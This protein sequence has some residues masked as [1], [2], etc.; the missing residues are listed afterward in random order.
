[1]HSWCRVLH[2][3][4]Y[5]QLDANQTL[6]SNSAG[7]AGFQFSFLFVVILFAP[8]FVELSETVAVD[9]LLQVAVGVV[10][11][12]AVVVEDK[13]LAILSCVGMPD[14][15]AVNIRIARMR[16]LRPYITHYVG[17]VLVLVRDRRAEVALRHTERVEA[18]VQLSAVHRAV[19]ARRAAG[20]HV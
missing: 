10:A 1:M 5:Q 9:E 19:R 6:T 18:V 16:E 7:Y 8:E 15:Q 13:Q 11:D 2:K 3:V 20:V 17:Q 14:G 12:V 4:Y